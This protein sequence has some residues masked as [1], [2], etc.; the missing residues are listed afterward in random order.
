MYDNLDRDAASAADEADI[1]DR[2][3]AALRRLA[4]IS[5]LAQE[6][7]NR[8]AGWHLLDMGRRVERAINTCRFARRLTAQ[9]APIEG[10]GVLLDL[11][12]SQITY[13]SRYLVG[14]S[15]PQVRDMA[16][17]D[18]YNPRSVAAQV[19]TIVAHLGKLP[20][21]NQDG[22]LEAPQRLALQLHSELATSIAASFDNAAVF[23]VAPATSSTSR[24]GLWLTRRSGWRDPMI[25]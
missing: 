16:L 4:A 11:I 15:L 18:T 1:T 5:G 3:E 24:R 23:A 6:N 2:V 25:Q 21:L 13:R 8:G 12:D 22:M 10:L 17:L 20:G 9:D 19:E 7:M 14:L